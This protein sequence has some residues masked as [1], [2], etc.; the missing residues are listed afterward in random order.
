MQVI[1]AKTGKPEELDPIK[2][3]EGLASGTH[4]PPPGQGVLLNPNSELVFV[5]AEDVPENV[6]KYGYKIPSP[7]ELR[8]I[9]RDFTYNTDS[10][11]LQAGLAGAARGGTFGVSDYLAVKTGLTSPEHL[12]ALKEYYPT[13]STVG[14]IGGAV[15][16]A[17][18]PGGP[19]GLLVKGARAAEAAAVGKAAAALPAKAAANLI[20]K[21]AV[22]TGGKALGGAIEGMAFGLGQSVSE[23]ALGDPD[24]TAEKVMANIGYGGLL[25]GG[26][27]AVLNVGSIG[28]RKALD[29]SKNVLQKAYDSLIG[30]TVAPGEAVAPQAGVSGFNI[31]ELGDE[32]EGSAADTLRAQIAQDQAEIAAGE[33]FEPGWLSKKLAKAA[34]A[35]SGVPEEQILQNFAAEMDPKRV[36]LT[37]AEKDAK[38]KTFGDNIQQIYETSQKLTK[39]MSKSARPQEMQGLLADT[40]IDAPLVQYRAVRDSLENAVKEMEKEPLLYDRYIFRQSEKM[41]ERMDDQLSKGFKSS[42]DV[43]KDMVTNR[44]LLEDLEQF[45]K[46]TLSRE[47][48]KA[49]SDFITPLRTS[50]KDGLTD[51]NIWGQAGARQAAYNEKFSA[52]LNW[53][54]A[55]E[56]TVMRKVDIGAPRPVYEINPTKINTMFNQINDFRSKIPGRSTS[57]FLKSFREYLEEAENTIKN[58]PEVK[59]DVTGLKD[60]TGKLSEEAL[61][62]KQYVSS[63]FGG[64]GFFRDLM[65][66]TK[67]GG[68]GGL[69]AQIGTIMTNPENL[70]T[71]LARIEKAAKDTS[72][73]VQKTSKFIFEKVKPPVKG[74]GII[75]Q[76]SPKDRTERYKKAIDKLK[77]LSDV[78]DA[79]LNEIDSATRETFEYA[80]RISQGLQLAAVRATTFL[81]SKMPQPPDKG[82]LDTPYEPSQAQIITFMRYNDVVNDPLI[83]LRQLEDNYVPPETIETLKTVYPSLY[84]DMKAQIVGE[85]TDK[86]AKGKVTLP[87]QR[88][89]VLSQFLEMPLDSSMNPQIIARNQETR[90][91]LAGEKAAEEA[92]KMA[93]PTQTGLGKVSLANR[94]QTGL[95]KVVARA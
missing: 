79:M 19:V 28:V 62:A 86:M 91:Q 94:N 80:P 89:I 5:P 74:A 8:K 17:F 20:A 84:S 70:V 81:Q 66:A 12:S 73:R 25:G 57:N 7:D 68:V 42:Y 27:G 77:T 44:Q 37:T 26:L 23:A 2:V 6:Y 75:I 93:A 13:A 90:A 33:Q 88:R 34:S 10:A 43:Y 53:T 38:V 9:G 56:K 46:I 65:D 45:N 15:G 92:Q 11:M 40:A 14:E 3:T 24:L 49:L 51:S 31:G 55:L 48:Q 95:E 61:A 32:L 52:L 41:L 87:Y 58:A 18:I 54:K 1:N 63:A 82:I 78:P 85:L 47:E 4:L 59:L 21:T 39:A 50:I 22:E 35:T 83:A 16:T 36:M 64:Y 60:F 29:K 30:K 76:E 72:K 71:F 67:S 69:A